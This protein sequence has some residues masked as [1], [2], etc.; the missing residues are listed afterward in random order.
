MIL[1]VYFDAFYKDL[2]KQLKN[3]NIPFQLVKYADLEHYNPTKP[4]TPFRTQSA[5]RGPPFS[6][7]TAPKGGVL[8][9]KRC[10]T[11]IITGSKQR[12]L[13]TNDFPLLDTY[14]TQDVHIIGICFG[15][16][17]LAFKTGGKVVEGP[18]FKG[19]RTVRTTR[20]TNSEHLYFN[21]HDRVID[22][23]D[24]WT[25]VQRID[26][27]INIAATKKWIGFQFH[28]EKDDEHFRHYVL[29]FLHLCAF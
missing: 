1:V 27:F 25:V 22:L 13:R 2:E 28:P 17:Y 26:G 29:P 9:E 18:L 6:L 23:P 5:Q 24:E 3:H 21:H 4:I 8:N 19:R 15:F 16:Q 11:I 7:I 20:E 12:I 10:K 14:M